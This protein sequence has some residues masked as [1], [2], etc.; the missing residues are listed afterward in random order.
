MFAYSGRPCWQFDGVSCPYG[1]ACRYAH[2]Y[3]ELG[4]HHDN[5]KKWPCFNGGACARPLCTYHH[6]VYEGL[7][8]EP[9]SG[10]MWAPATASAAVPDTTPPALSGQEHQAVPAASPE[11]PLA[12]LL[13]SQIDGEEDCRRAIA[14]DSSSVKVC[15]LSSISE[16]KAFASRFSSEDKPLHVLFSETKFDGTLQYARNKKATRS[17]Y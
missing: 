14:I 1:Q 3:L 16:V 2:G 7:Q 5:C 17:G 10:P 8:R 9:L 6:G 13:P 12:S 15:D 4:L 11:H